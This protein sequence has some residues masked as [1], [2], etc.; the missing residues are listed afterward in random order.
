MFAR[1]PP[2]FSSFARAIPLRQP[3]LNRTKFAFLL[4][5]R[6]M[7]TLDKSL[8]PLSKAVA[9]D[10]A[11]MYNH[12]QAYEAA[13]KEGDAA[14]QGRIVRLLIWEVSRHAVSEELTLYPLM[15]KRLPDG[16]RLADENRREHLEVKKLFDQL[17]KETPGSDT[18]HSLVQKTWEQ[19][20][21]HNSSEERD[22]LPQLEKCFENEAE[23]ESHAKSFSRI[24][25]IVPTR[26]HSGAPDRPPLETIAGM[27]TAPLDKIQDLFSHFP[28]E[29]D[30]KV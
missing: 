26:G 13:K 1:P 17:Q 15:E 25:T 29:E 30:L 27:L 9:E 4:Q 8:P 3:A 2:A 21:P 11:D 14:R 23:S 6:T 18:F 5:S 20:S 22:E 7:S 19:L 12:F 16:R 24:K 10:H 28:S